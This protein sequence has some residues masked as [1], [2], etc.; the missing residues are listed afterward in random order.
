VT[1][2]EVLT[3]AAF[4]RMEALGERLAHGVQTVIERH[5]LPWHVVRIGGRVE[6]HFSLRPLRNGAEGAA[7]IDQDV[8][9]YL[10]LFALNR[11][12]M[13]FPFHNRA[14]VCAAH[15]DA[16]VDRHTAVLDAAAGELVASAGR[17][18]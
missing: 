14:L 11:G 15:V 7:L 17:P 12:V 10:H 5:A 18:G 16:D 6:Y 2:E 8:S 4:A 13:V 3:D 9:S 1:L